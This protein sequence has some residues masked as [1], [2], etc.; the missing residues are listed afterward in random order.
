MITQ[1]FVKH[2]HLFLCSHR[3]QHPPSGVTG[4][5]V[6][7]RKNDNGHAQH[8]EDRPCVEYLR[9]HESQI[10]QEH[11]HHVDDRTSNE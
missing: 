5:G 7:D 1:L 4:N 2:I 11:E 10:L 6:D 3:P 9:E 8:H